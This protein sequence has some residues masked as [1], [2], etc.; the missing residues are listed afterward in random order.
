[1]AHRMR[2]AAP[3]ASLAPEDRYVTTKQ[4]RVIV[5]ASDMTYWRWQ[6]DPEVGFPSPVKLGADGRN[7][8]S[9]P[10]VR[11]WISPAR[12]TFGADQCN[13][14]AGRQY[15]RVIVPSA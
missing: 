12:G 1:M 8:W 14:D 4:L 11:E 9:L 3:P 13:S 6:R 7:Y 15:R 2:K 5:P 10:K